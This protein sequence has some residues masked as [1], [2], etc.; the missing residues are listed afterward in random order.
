MFSDSASPLASALLGDS[1][2]WA[3]ELVAGRPIR[4]AV[5]GRS[6]VDDGGLNLELPSALIGA[7][8]EIELNETHSRHIFFL[9]VLD[10]HVHAGWSFLFHLLPPP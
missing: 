1:E 6:V 8:T 2:G 7:K 9:G 5:V 3:L 4:E 10:V